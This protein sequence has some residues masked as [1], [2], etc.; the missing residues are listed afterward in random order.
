MCNKKTKIKKIFIIGL[1]FLFS[2]ACKKDTSQVVPYVQVNV[3]LNIATDLASLGVNSAIICPLQGGYK[4]IIIYRAE[5]NEF[6]AYERL[7]TNYPNDTCAVATE[8]GSILGTC[9]CCKSQFELV[10][11]Y[12]NKGPARLPLKQYQTTVEGGRLYITN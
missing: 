7:C 3:V 5:Q 10:T 12:V 1:V 2:T 9:P 6:K 11:G 4:G 8:N